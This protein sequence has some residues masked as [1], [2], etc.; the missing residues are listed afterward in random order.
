ME[1]KKKRV[2]FPYEWFD[3]TDKLDDT[4]L[5]PMGDDLFSSMKQKSV[6]DDGKQSPL[7]NYKFL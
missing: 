2:F 4:K 3:S 5:P 1:W 6:L 7:E